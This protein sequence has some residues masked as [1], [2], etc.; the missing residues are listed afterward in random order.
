MAATIT[1][2]TDRTDTTGSDNETAESTTLSDRSSGDSAE[3]L[4]LVGA[5][6]A[7]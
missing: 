7:A 6:L 4:D 2:E 5:L 3:P 1:P